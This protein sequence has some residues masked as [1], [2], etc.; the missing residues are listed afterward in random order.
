[1]TSG[2]T[3]TGGPGMAE[4]ALGEVVGGVERDKAFRM[5]GGGKNLRRVIDTDNLMAVGPCLHANHCK[6]TFY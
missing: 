1:M 4:A 5:A 3:G 2:A 6:N